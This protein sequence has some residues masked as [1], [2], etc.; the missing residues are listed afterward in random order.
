[1]LKTRG[2]TNGMT[3]GMT[4]DMTAEKVIMGL[5]LRHAL[6]SK[7]RLFAVN[8]MAT[9]AFAKVV[10]DMKKNPMLRELMQQMEQQTIS[11]RESGVAASTPVRRPGT[12]SVV[13]THPAAPNRR[14]AQQ[15]LDAK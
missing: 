1:M 4:N 12:P 2:T 14:P 5:A 15:H 9:P 7:Q 6:L 11:L 10:A 13:P 8:I 3:K